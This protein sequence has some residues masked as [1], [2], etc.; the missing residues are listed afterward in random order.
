[1]PPPPPPGVFD[2]PFHMKK[3]KKS[4]RPV[5]SYISDDD[6]DIS[7]TPR[8][9]TVY[10]WENVLDRLDWED[11][12]DSHV[13]RLAPFRQ[14]VYV[15]MHPMTMTDLRQHLWLIKYAV[16][17]RWSY[18]PRELVDCT[19]INRVEEAYA[20]GSRALPPRAL[21]YLPSVG[22][23][24]YSD[25]LNPAMPT[26]HAAA[27]LLTEVEARLVYVCD[28]ADE[29]DDKSEKTEKEDD[30]C[31]VLTDPPCKNC[32]E[33]KEERVKK[34]RKADLV[35]YIVMQ[36]ETHTNLPAYKLIKTGTREGAA[37]RIFYEA[38]AKGHSTVFVC[39]MRSDAE[40]IR[41]P[42]S[43]YEQI[44]DIFELIEPEKEGKIR[45][46]F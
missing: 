2:V 15:T 21:D 46:F 17:E 36:M 26:M 11:K 6:S 32:S 20:M 35:Y 18:P 30:V 7:S 25:R 45:V 23:K 16:P 34:L 28:C 1:M 22:E 12:Y 42:D 43:A 39:A 29:P 14:D 44:D 40:P 3:G 27:A 19:L 5:K 41:C 4:K 38:G 37:S 31:S 24:V 13:L 9:R 33:Q 8:R 10:T